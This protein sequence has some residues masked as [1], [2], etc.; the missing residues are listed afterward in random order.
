M[1][2]SLTHHLLGFLPVLCHCCLS[3]ISASR[4]HLEIKLLAISFLFQSLLLK[5]PKLRYHGRQYEWK[6][7]RR[8]GKE[9]WREDER[10]REREKERKAGRKIDGIIMRGERDAGGGGMTAS[11]MKEG[12]G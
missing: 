7:G 5:K 3:L 2:S 11:L 8:E 9:G 12:G 6:E 10:N 4:S 1:I